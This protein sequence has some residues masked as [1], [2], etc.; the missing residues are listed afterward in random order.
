MWKLVFP[1]VFTHFLSLDFFPS[2]SSLPFF[3]FSSS[4]YGVGPGGGWD[5]RNISEPPPRRS[6]PPP[7]DATGVAAAWVIITL[8][9]FGHT[10]SAL[11]WSVGPRGCPGES[12][13]IP[14]TCSEDP[15]EYRGGYLEVPGGSLG[16]PQ[17][18]NS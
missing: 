1:S 13:G 10:G 14:G 17:C 6:H 11:G 18:L 15:W 8:G 7:K 16:L 5:K 4:C 9:T 2:Y 3:L 12:W